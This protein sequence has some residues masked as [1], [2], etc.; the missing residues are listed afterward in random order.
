MRIMI[1]GTGSGCGKTT[2]SMLLMACLRRQGLSVQPYKA[3]PD[4][5]DPGFHRRICGRPCYNLDTWLMQEKTLFRLLDTDADI[6]V[7]EGVMGYYDGMEAREMRASSWELAQ[8]THTPVLLTL[9][10]SGSAASAAAVVKGFETLR[11]GSDLCGVLVNRASGE[12]HYERVRE[13]VE[14]YTGLPCLGWLKRQKDLE[15]PSRHLGLVT[16]RETPDLAARID[17][18]AEEAEKTLDLSGILSLAQQAPGFGQAERGQRL[19]H[20]RMGVAMDEAFQFYYDANL[21]QI[22]DWGMEVVPFS[23]LH[24]RALPEGLDALYIGGGYPEVY[25]AELEGNE[26]M[27]RQIRSVLEAGLPCYA[28]CGGFMYLSRDIDGHEMCGQLPVR[29]RMTG[30]LQHFGYVTV[31]DESGLSFPAHEFHR[32]EAI[33][34]P[35]AVSTWTIQKGNGSGESWK[36]GYRRGHTLGGF[37]YVHFADRPEVAGLLWR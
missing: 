28:E 24:D 15:L 10:A 25:A 7:I 36:G 20:G 23:P 32:A 16:A 8:V 21:E 9:D 3:G 29:C 14:R 37:A 26:R 4:Y 35:E 19:W 27:R 11:E 34:E 18:A 31:R 2:C 5:I 12:S 22:R 1:A 30:R 17:R 13:A 6:G 33:A